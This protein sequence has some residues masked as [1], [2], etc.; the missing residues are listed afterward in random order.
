VF[1]S[2]KI[3]TAKNVAFLG[4]KKKERIIKKKDRESFTP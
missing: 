4:E 3:K 2:K 1:Y